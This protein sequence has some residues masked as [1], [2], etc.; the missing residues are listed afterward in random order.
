MVCIYVLIPEF[1]YVYIYIHVYVY[2]CVHIY[3]YT[4][5]SLS[6]CAGYSL[7]KYTNRAHD[8]AGLHV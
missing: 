8:H 3:V 5:V 4:Y 1:R 6:L 2:T 7:N